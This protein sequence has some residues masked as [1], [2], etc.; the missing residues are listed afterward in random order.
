MLTN[1]WRWRRSV[2]LRNEPKSNRFPKDSLTPLVSISF[3]PVFHSVFFCFCIYRKH[4]TTATRA[5]QQQ[6]RNV[7]NVN[8]MKHT[9]IE[10]KADPNIFVMCRYKYMTEPV[11]GFFIHMHR[12][13]SGISLQKSVHLE[14]F[15][16]W[17][18]LG[19]DD[20]KHIK[21]KLID[22]HT[23]NGIGIFIYRQ[24]IIY[25]WSALMDFGLAFV[26]FVSSSSYK[27]YTNIRTAFTYAQ[28]Q[29]TQQHNNVSMRRLN[30]WNLI[31][32]I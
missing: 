4:L 13:L 27:K 12:H 29:C 23:A 11:Y 5:E 8:V 14:L 30:K 22:I 32:F 20:E 19:S 6:K 9:H 18:F 2:F 26:G 31:Y 3:H 21:V 24:K 25:S 17:L 16:I 10:R 15:N 7:Q 1:R 28:I